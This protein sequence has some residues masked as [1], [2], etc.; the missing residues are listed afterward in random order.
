MS[1]GES[2]AELV[3]ASHGTLK[4]VQG[5]TVKIKFNQYKKDLQRSRR[6]EIFL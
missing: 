5:D 3:S 1:K 4:R 2:H 6:L